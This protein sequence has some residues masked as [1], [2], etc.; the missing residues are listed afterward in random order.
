MDNTSESKQDLRRF[1]IGELKSE[2]CH[3]DRPKR[4]GQA[5]CGVCWC[6]LPPEL[7]DELYRPVGG[8]FEAAY[9][10]AVLFLGD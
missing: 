5:V 9:E 6:R 1:Y 4:R 7:R 3:C 2:Q 10:A 8:G